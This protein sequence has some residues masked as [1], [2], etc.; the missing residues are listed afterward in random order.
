[1]YFCGVW[2][3]ISLGTHFLLVR[4]PMG[5]V[6][7]LHLCVDRAT[8][9]SRVL[10]SHRHCALGLANVKSLVYVVTHRKMEPRG[11]RIAFQD[12]MGSSAALVLAGA[13]IFPA[14]IGLIRKMSFLCLCKTFWGASILLIILR[15]DP[16]MLADDLL[17]A[18]NDAS[19]LCYAVPPD[20][21]HCPLKALTED[22]A[23]E[24]M[25]PM[26]CL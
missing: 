17:N 21:T 13:V 16:A 18:F 6:P 11:A 24:R 1:M 7:L 8:T 12:R 22:I 15:L 23:L 25:P 26:F 19:G 10:H 14:A 2:R 3:T 4:E 9:H 5:C 20:V